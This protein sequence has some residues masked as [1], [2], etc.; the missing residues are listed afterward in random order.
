MI[1]IFGGAYQGKLEYA[2]EHW[3]FGDNDVFFCDE[4]LAID[5]SKK[6]ICGLEKFV[7]ACVLEGAEAKDV[8]KMYDNEAPLRDKIWLVDDISQGVVP[9]DPDR[10][11]WRESVGRT[12]LWLGKESDEVHRVFCGLGQRLK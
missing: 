1:L 9:I 4:S 11:A 7:Y 8:L 3:D 12:L 5:L 10:R 6:V 2:R